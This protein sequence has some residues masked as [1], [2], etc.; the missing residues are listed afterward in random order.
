MAR[1]MKRWE[2]PRREGRNEKGKGGSA[3]QRQLKKQTKM[4]RKKLKD[5][6][7]GHNEG[8]GHT[9]PSFAFWAIALG[10]L[11]GSLRANP[12]GDRPSSLQIKGRSRSN[13]ICS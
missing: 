12:G 8:R 7:S 9:L 1:M 3:R 2:S 6:A 4:L 11:G 13:D 10:N 5:D